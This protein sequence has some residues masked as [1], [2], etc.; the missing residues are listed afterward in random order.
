MSDFPDMFSA[1]GK[2]QPAALILPSRVTLSPQLIHQSTVQLQPNRNQLFF[3]F[4]VDTTVN[5]LVVQNTRQT[6][7]SKTS[8]CEER[9]DKQIQKQSR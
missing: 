5:W 3:R 1:I 8:Q 2:Q 6:L 4:L 9:Q 7:T